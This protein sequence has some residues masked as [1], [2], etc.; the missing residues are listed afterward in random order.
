MNREQP[1]ADCL[2]FKDCMEQRGICTE[3]KTLE[4]VRQEIEKLNE[5]QKKAPRTTAT[6]DAGDIQKRGRRRG[7]VYTDGRQTAK[8]A[9]D[10]W[11]VA[12]IVSE[13]ENEEAGRDRPPKQGDSKKA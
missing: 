3:Y 2:Y 12:A 10:A 5:N 7:K 13:A 6:S 9:H 11:K 4:Q 8:A 1:C